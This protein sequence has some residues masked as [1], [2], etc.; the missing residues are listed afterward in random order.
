MLA[1]TQEQ[2]DHA[3]TL[4]R[5][6]YEEQSPVI[7]LAAAK[8]KG[9]ESG[10]FMGEPL[11]Q[12]VGDAEAALAAAP[13]K[14]DVK[15]TTPRHHHAP[16]ELHACTLA[17]EGETLR[18]YDASQAVAHEAWTIAQVFGLK[19]DQ[20]RLT[21]PFVGGGFG[22]KL[23]WQHQI[24]AAAAAKLAGRPVRI[25]LSREGVFRIVG[26]RTVTEQRVA[27]G[28]QADG[29]FY[30]LI[31]TGVVA[32]T[33]HNNMPEP[34][35]L[36]AK[37]VYASKTFFLDVETVRM[38]MVANTFMR[39]PGE[40]VG[41]FGSNG[42]DELA[43]ELGLDPIELRIRNEPERDPLTGLPFSQRGIVQAWRDGAARF[44]W[45]KRS[46]TPA[47]KH[48]GDWRIGMGCATGTYPYYRMPGGAARLTITRE[49]R[50]TVAIA[51]HEMGMGTATAQ[52]Q[53][54]AERLGLPLEQVQVLYGDTLFPGA[55]LAGGSQQSASIGASMIAA[56]RA[57]VK[58]LL[59]LAGNESALAGLGPDEVGGLDGG[60]CALEDE[61][62]CERT[63]RSSG[64]P[65]GRR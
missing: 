37:S 56:H 27:L 23:L 36:P 43:V 2:A 60:L 33:P 38:N 4:I 11:K 62:R 28:A 55:V 34:F 63:P 29:R 44:G 58:E 51:A 49:G 47:A 54:A 41:T 25:M 39:A 22:S 52:A 57:L 45:D 12:K 14:V 50:A 3:Q 10:L 26:G 31:H 32:M 15:Y 30:A 7:A 46:A 61:F 19:D 5:V 42:M 64:A 65:G 8:A 1:E 6:T 16:I 35:I 9:G 13:H 59:K 40:A 17:W 21:S 48:E 20:V 53:V 18:I 24:L